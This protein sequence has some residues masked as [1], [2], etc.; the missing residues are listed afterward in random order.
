VALFRRAKPAP[1]PVAP[2]GGARR[3]RAGGKGRPTPKRQR[4][5]PPPPPPTSRKE[6]YARL[7]ERSREQQTKARTGMREGDDRYVLARD[8]GPVRRLVRDI[9]DSRR[10]VGSYSFGVAIVIFLVSSTPGLSP[11][12][13]LAV[14]YVWLVIIVLIFVD[15]Y[16]LSRI[17]RRAVLARFPDEKSRMRGH[18]W[19]GVIRA[20]TFRRLRT[21]RPQVK[22]GE[23]V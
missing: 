17:I 20:L 15:S 18:S 5:A 6:A 19:Y 16:V 23:P 14:S 10:N 8:R 13:R 12:V 4:A 11:V 9:V 3:E 7:R 1:E 21:P 22:I 2:P